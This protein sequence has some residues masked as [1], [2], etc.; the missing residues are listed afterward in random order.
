[1]KKWMLFF[2][3]WSITTL[4]AQ[5]IRKTERND[6]GWYVVTSTIKLSEKFKLAGEYQFRRT[7][8]GETWQ[9]SLLRTGLQ[10]QVNSNLKVRAGYAWIVTF[11]Y[12][13]TSLNAL[14]RTFP[15]HRIYQAVL[16]EAPT[17]KLRFSNRY[18]FEQRFVG[19]FHSATDPKPYEYRM[20]MR[21]R[22]LVRAETTVGFLSKGKMRTYI[23]AWD[24]IFIGFGRN[25]GENVFDQNRIALIAGVQPNKHF[26]IEGGFF[27]QFV[28]VGREIHN[29]NVF[30][31]NTGVNLVANLEF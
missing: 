18:M 7:H 28:Q 10:Y 23:G 9:Q 26:R 24:E 25:V 13:E 12:G 14:G 2:M 21:A 5:S 22:A 19:Y 27:E 16:T 8:W 6:I 29:Q 11:P 20:L 31:Y 15:E 4:M 17:G 30:Q 1:M 3:L